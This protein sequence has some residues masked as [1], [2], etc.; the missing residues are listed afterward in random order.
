M[1][2][3]ILSGIIFL[4]ILNLITSFDNFTKNINKIRKTN[5]K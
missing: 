1:L 3:I 2:I 4:K 5:N